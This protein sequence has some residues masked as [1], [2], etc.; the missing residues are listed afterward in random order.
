MLTP[1][2][3]RFDNPCSNPDLS[4]SVDL[5]SARVVAK[6]VGSMTRV[7]SRVRRAI[8]AD[9]WTVPGAWVV[10]FHFN[11]STHNKVQ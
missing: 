4:Q 8:Q 10:D 5:G 1:C 3:A 2:T 11:G 7:V 9:C 6:I